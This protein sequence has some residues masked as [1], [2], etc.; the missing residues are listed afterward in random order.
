MWRAVVSTSRCPADA[1]LL[2]RAGRSRRKPPH[3]LKLNQA[4]KPKGVVCMAMQTVAAVETE[5]LQRV[6]QGHYRATSP[7][8]QMTIGSAG[9][10]RGRRAA[11]DRA[12]DPAS[13]NASR[14]VGSS[15]SRHSRAGKC[16]L[17]Q[18][19]WIEPGGSSSLLLA[20][21]SQQ[22]DVVVLLCVRGVVFNLFLN[23]RQQRG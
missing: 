7:A 22:S 5:R 6:R 20:P 21:D 23:L 14:A 8:R 12:V 3:N 19:Q 18:D 13:A 17:P 4:G 10:L 11:W 15:P 1:R 9:R 16:G 2:T